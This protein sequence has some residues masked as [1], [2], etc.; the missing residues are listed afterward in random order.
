M[1]AGN[2]IQRLAAALVPPLDNPGSV[3]KRIAIVAAT[4]DEL[5]PLVQ[6][7]E[8]EATQHTF[9]SFQLHQL[10]IDLLY[11]GIG[12]MQTMYNLMDYIG[13][14]HPDGWLQAGIGGAF[15]RSLSLATTYQV[16][17]ETLIGFGAQQPDG[18]IH[19]PFKMGWQDENAFPYEDGWLTCPFTPKW[20]LQ[21]AT[22]MTSFYAHGN[23]DA[24]ELLS[25]ARTGQIENMEGAPFFYVSLIKKIPFLSIR[26]ISNYVERRNV[27]AWKIQDS[28]KALGD[29]LME[30]LVSHEYN[31]DRMF[32]IGG[33]TN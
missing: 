7:L 8:R 6:F 11:S 18:R 23:V 20:D 16:S 12:V 21:P 3:N 24:I 10:Q 26:S 25:H 32:G 29:V 1:V 9:Q 27:G 4:R 15:D 14:R 19:D 2:I 30:W 13:H 17:S 22:G 31:C 33:K 5:Q 28:I